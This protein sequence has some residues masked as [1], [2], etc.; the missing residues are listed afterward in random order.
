MLNEID[1]CQKTLVQPRRSRARIGP[2]LLRPLHPTANLCTKILDFIGFDSSRILMFLISRGGILMPIGHPPESLSQGILEGTICLYHI[3]IY[4]YICVYIYIHIYIY[5]QRERYIYI[6][7][8]VCIYA[9]L[10]RRF[11]V[12]TEP[13]GEPSRREDIILISICLYIYI[14]IYIVYM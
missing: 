11:P 2:R 5:I 3:Y 12:G 13:A 10:V 14:Y 6:Y 4:I 7:I 1:D 9:I 8:H